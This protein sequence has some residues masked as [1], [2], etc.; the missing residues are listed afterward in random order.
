LFIPGLA[1]ATLGFTRTGGDLELVG[2]AMG[3]VHAL[4]MAVWFGGLVLLSRVVLAGPGEDD[5]VHATRGF[6]RLATPAL[7]LT[8]VSGAVQVI[9][10]DNGHLFDSDHGRLLLLKMVPTAAMVFVGIATRQF[11]RQQLSRADE[12]SAPMAGRLRRAIGTE[13]A[14]GVAVLLVTSWMVSS[15]P[16]NLEVRPRTADKF[17]YRHE[18]VDDVGGLDVLLAINPSEV[19]QNELYLD[20][21]KPESGISTIRVQFD[22]PAS[23]TTGNGVVMTLQDL[24]GAGIAYAPKG[25]NLLKLNTAGPW[26]V[27]IEVV[28]S[29]GTLRQTGIINVTSDDD[30]KLNPLP[31]VTAPIVTSP[32]EVS[33]TTTTTVAGAVPSG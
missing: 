5:L 19:G 22:P 4:A 24:H 14:F 10:L 11:I 17:V 28:T 30:T 13:A 15:H 12:M 31:A 26:N 2:Y 6:A 8:V 25:D 1:V 21:R 16:A 29:T 23:A 20:V 3:V 32:P 7:L 9:R 27:T 33:T 18:F